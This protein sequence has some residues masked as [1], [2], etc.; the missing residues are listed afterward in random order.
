[1]KY[2]E[3]KFR[4]TGISPILGSIAMDKKVFTEYL[5]TKGKTDEEQQKAMADVEN[6][7]EAGEGS[8]NKATGFYRDE[9]GNFI[10][11]EYQV[12]GFLKEAARC[13]KDQLGLVAPVS[14]ID[15]FVFIR[16]T[17]LVIHTPT[18]GTVTEASSILD[19]PLRAMTAQG[20]RVALAYSEM[21][22]DWCIEFTLRVLQ[23][24]GSKK[25]VAM[26]MDIIE[27]LLE[28]GALKGLLQWR[29]GGYGKFTFEKVGSRTVNE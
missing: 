22:D 12:K 18:G 23:N 29:N 6:V 27:E 25:S 24:E 9:H 13:L 2:T 19:R 11:K 14:K 17:N 4:L 26:T 16:E 10:L 3:Q 7:P 21:V 1:M 8:D 20:P 28:Y 5:A 15:N